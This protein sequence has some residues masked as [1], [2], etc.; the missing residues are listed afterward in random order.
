MILKDKPI[1]WKS[2]QAYGGLKRSK[3]KVV[4]LAIRTFGSNDL[5]KLSQ[6]VILDQLKLSQRWN[7]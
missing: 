3:P 5:L 1:D 6:R 7:I 2:F 4:A